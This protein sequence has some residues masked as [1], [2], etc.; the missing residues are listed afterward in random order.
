MSRTRTGSKG[1]GYEYWGRRPCSG[2][3]AGKENKR[4][5]HQIERAREKALILD[6]IKEMEDDRDDD[7]LHPGQ[8]GG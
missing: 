6:E 5:T 3:H 4:H 7:S 8:Q 2:F 1:P